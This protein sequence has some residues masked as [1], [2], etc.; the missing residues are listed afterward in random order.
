MIY[1]GVIFDLDGTL[2]DATEALTLSWARALSDEP[3]VPRPPSREELEQV[4]GMTDRQLVEVIFPYLS[5]A[6]G[7]ELFEK[8]S[9][10]QNDYLR[11]NGGR[12]YEGLVPALQELAGKLPL[13]IVS[14]CNN[15]YIPAF[16]QAH[17]LSGLFRDWECI[18]RTGKEKWE[19]ILLVAQRGGLKRPVYV[20]DTP[21]DMLSAQKAGVP[22]VHAAYGFGR[23]T[24]V[25]AA[26]CPG[27]LP[28][29][30]LR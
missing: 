8:C 9:R 5:P 7:L 30:L 1:D 24:G 19:N 15:G 23:V 27:M 22:F 6:R 29:L 18:G 14:N 13:F 16:L 25:P 11:R 3:D 10:V 20:G 17:G 12:L 26:D 21:M 2:W 4:M 28:K